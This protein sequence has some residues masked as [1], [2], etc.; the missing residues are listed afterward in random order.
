M[1]QQSV[2]KEKNRQNLQSS[3][4]CACLVL[5][6]MGICESSADPVGDCASRLLSRFHYG[7]G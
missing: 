3:L 4:V 5:H 7:L 1:V 6:P 2:S